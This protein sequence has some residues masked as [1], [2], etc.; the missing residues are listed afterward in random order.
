M[1][2]VEQLHKVNEVCTLK[3][4]ETFL[5]VKFMSRQEAERIFPLTFHRVKY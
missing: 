2:F 3:I 4:I 5:A 1:T